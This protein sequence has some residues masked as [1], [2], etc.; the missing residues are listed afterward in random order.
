[1]YHNSIQTYD[2]KTWK[3][4]YKQLLT[5]DFVGWRLILSNKEEKSYTMIVITV[6]LLT[7]LITK[8]EKKI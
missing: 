1:M 4:L 3:M 2:L 6:H 8:D 5:F 7:P